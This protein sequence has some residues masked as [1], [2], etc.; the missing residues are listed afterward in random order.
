MFGVAG[1]RLQLLGQRKRMAYASWAAIGVLG[2]LCGGAIAGGALGWLG[3]L[4]PHS[5]IR[6][7]VVLL[8]IACF[9]WSAHEFALLELPMPQLHR[10]VPRRWMGLLPWNWVA[11]GYGLQLG[12]GVSTRITVSTTYSAFALA[13]LSGS[14]LAGAAIGSAFGIAR[15]VMPFWA[16]RRIQSPQ[17]SMALAESLAA[18]EPRMRR[19]NGF[20][21]GIAGLALTASPWFATGAL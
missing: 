17:E 19:L 16:S 18:R 5:A 11:F 21:L 7:V 12:S 14:P 4:L 13:L 3:S 10:Q 1:L 15:A 20:A 9:A 2:H 6:W 8:G